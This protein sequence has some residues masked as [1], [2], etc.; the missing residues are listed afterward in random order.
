MLIEDVHWIDPTSLELI[1]R[2]IER[3][4]HFAGVSGRDV[5]AGISG[6]LGLAA[7]TSPTLPLN[8]FGRSQA[9]SMVDR[10]MS[11]KTLP[12]EVLNQIVAKTDGVPLFVEELTKS[13][14]ESGLLREEDDAYVL[15][16]ALTPLAIPVDLAR[17]ADGAARSAV[18]DQGNRA[19]RRRDRTRVL[20]YAAGSG[21]ADQGT[22]VAGCLHQLIEAELIY[23]RG[24]PPT[25]SYIFKHALVQDTAY[26]SLLRGRRQR[27]HADI[28]QTS[29]AT[30]SAG[31]EAAPAI[32]AHHY[33][34]S[35]PCR[36]GRVALAGSRR[37]GAVAIGLDG[38]GAA[39]QRRPRLDPA[40][41]GRH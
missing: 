17:F 10:I 11:G 15:A 8:R 22:D 4:Q 39:R 28:A 3:V 31:E 41:R 33:H 25:V 1:G 5:P 38:S 2:L 16:A 34:R 9:V 19:D 29:Q 7:R 37:T 18:A 35:G 20:A 23:Q 12:T 26:I 36:T 40:H 13:V 14:L 32:I 6:A 30:R 27:I 24:V 21:L